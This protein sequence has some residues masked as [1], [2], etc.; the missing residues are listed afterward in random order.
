M[1]CYIEQSV[2]A[3]KSFGKSLLYALSWCATVLLVIMAMFFGTGVFSDQ[4]DVFK[5]HWMNV[6]LLLLCLLGAFVCY[7][8]KDR[9]RMEYDYILRGKVLEISGILNARRRHK[10][11]EISL[12]CILQIG[13]VAGMQIQDLQLKKHSWFSDS[14]SSISY[15][16]YMQERT[17][18]MAFLELNTEMLAALRKCGQIPR[19]AWR[20][21][22]GKSLN[23]ASL[24]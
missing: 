11:A 6:V 9:L 24:S 16:I 8:R 19:D 3:K 7:R 14:Q 12:D 1:E 23:Y 20:D 21:E 4:P 22:E 15:I 18:H 13:P 2:T 10:L 5:I 17:R